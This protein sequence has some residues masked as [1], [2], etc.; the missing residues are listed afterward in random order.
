[1]LGLRLFLFPSAQRSARS[2]SYHLLIFF[3]FRFIL[4]MAALGLL[5]AH[6]LSL[7]VVSYSV[8]VF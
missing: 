8:I 2:K 3:F 6:R 7:I 1:M 5:A 4:L